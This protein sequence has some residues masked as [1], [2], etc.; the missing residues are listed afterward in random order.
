MTFVR[1]S[2][3]GRFTRRAV[4]GGVATCQ[5]GSGVV[6]VTSHPPTHTTTCCVDCVLTAGDQDLICN[7]LGNRRWV[8]GLEVGAGIRWAVAHWQGTSA[9]GSIL[10]SFPSALC[11]PGCIAW[12][13]DKSTC[14]LQSQWMRS[15]HN[16]RVAKP[17]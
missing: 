5:G 13:Q 14:L 12:L 3:T 11:A 17:C 16:E 1:T 2:H 15:T 4:S 8:D 6:T 7:W 9:A 10:L